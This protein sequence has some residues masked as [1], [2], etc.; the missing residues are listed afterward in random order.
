MKLISAVLKQ[1]HFNLGPI[2]QQFHVFALVLCKAQVEPFR[3]YKEFT[4]KAGGE[5]EAQENK[6]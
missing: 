1:I 3:K 2:F 5:Q 6:P 4:S